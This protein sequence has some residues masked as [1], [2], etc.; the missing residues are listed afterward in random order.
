MKAALTWYVMTYHPRMCMKGPV[1]KLPPGAVFNRIFFDKK[2]PPKAMVQIF[3][4]GEPQILG[5]GAPLNL[6]RGVL[7]GMSPHTFHLPPPDSCEDVEIHITPARK[8]F[9]EPPRVNIIVSPSPLSGMKGGFFVP[10]GPP[11]KKRDW[12]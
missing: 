2:I 1:D 12:Q 3:V 7:E 4:N 8:K 9:T 5:D 6:I 10:L 11:R